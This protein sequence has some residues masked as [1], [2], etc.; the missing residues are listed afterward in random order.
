MIG[1]EAMSLWILSENH[2]LIGYQ[3][4]RIT[5]KKKMCDKEVKSRLL[6]ESELFVTGSDET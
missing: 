5:R 2:G 1:R 3:M 6:G 4:Q